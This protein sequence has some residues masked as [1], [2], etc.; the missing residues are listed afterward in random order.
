MDLEQGPENQNVQTLQGITSGDVIAVQIFGTEIPTL[1]GFQVSLQY[2]P[3]S[4]STNSFAFEKGALIPDALAVIAHAENAVTAG[5]AATGKGSS[6][7]KSGMMGTMNFVIADSFSDSTS[8]NLTTATFSLA[9][10]TVVEVERHSSITLSAE[11]QL[12]GD[13]DGDSTVG[14]SD[15][16]QFAQVFG[17]QSTDADYDSR[18]DLDSD[19]MVGFSDFLIFAA[20]FGSTG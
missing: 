10:G 5:A 6:E 1:N 14:F 18:F 11:S 19:G 3:A 2:D 8:L 4:I 13:F 17:K 20:S 9:D 7:K 16:L 12:T 15:F